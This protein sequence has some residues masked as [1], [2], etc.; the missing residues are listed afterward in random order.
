MSA[1]IYILQQAYK[2]KHCTSTG[3]VPF[4][5][6]ERDNRNSTGVFATETALFTHTVMI[7]DA[8][9]ENIQEL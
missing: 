3:D 6:W 4:P 9:C 2:H 5:G 8:K 7:V 1:D